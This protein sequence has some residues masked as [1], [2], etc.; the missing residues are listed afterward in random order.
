ME[1]K[2]NHWA[3]EIEKYL[4]TSELPVDKK[5]G[6][7]IRRRVSQFTKVDKVL[8]KWGFMPLLLRCI[9]P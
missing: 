9:S 8:Y 7:K 2:E 3:G 4:D 6:R 1:F 5:D